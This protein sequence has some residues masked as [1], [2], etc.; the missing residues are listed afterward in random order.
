MSVT[1]CQQESSRF[2]VTRRRAR[3]RELYQ[4]NHSRLL[5]AQRFTAADLK[6][7]GSDRLIDAVGPRGSEDQIIGPTLEFDTEATYVFVMPLRSDSVPLLDDD[8][9]RLAS[10]WLGA[11]DDVDLA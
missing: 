8:V 6:N 11:H 2:A 1:R 9:R 10:D 3:T 5:I 7:R 4:E